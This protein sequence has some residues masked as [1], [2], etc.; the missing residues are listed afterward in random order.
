PV[1][2]YGTA[3]EL[4]DDLERY[5][6]GDAVRAR[7]PSVAY[8]LRKGVAKRKAVIVALLAIAGA[9]ATGIVFIPR[10]IAAQE[11]VR[12]LK[13]LGALWMEIALAKQGFF[14]PAEDP[15]KVR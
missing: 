6:R 9:A 13:E 1:R 11:E 8:R 14:M 12:S 3:A 4:A 5:L 15:L 2:R 10:W 7:P